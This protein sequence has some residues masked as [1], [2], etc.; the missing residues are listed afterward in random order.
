VILVDLLGL[1]QLTIA[2]GMVLALGGIALL[3]GPACA[4]EFNSASQRVSDSS[5]L[6]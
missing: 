1:K 6:S 4:G 3:L 5:V 2:F